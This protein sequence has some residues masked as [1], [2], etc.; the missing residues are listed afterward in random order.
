MYLCTYCVC[1]CW[2]DTEA[3]QYCSADYQTNNLLSPVLFEEGLRSVPG[4]AML[5]EIAPHGLLQAILKRAMPDAL[6]VP[7]TQRGHADPMRF[8]LGAVGK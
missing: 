2:Q 8:L 1:W 4:R 3:A 6:H 5:V 7:L